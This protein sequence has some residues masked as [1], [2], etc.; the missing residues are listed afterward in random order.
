MTESIPL[1]LLT[2]FLGSGKTTLLNYL[3]QQP[4]FARSLVI[5]NE[6]GD[7]SLD[8]LLVT[9][10]A[11]DN[12]VQLSSGCICCS[13][14]GD[15][16]KTLRDISW[17]F[18]RNGVRQFEQV[19]IE[20][21]GL[22]APAAIIHTVMAEPKIARQ[23][24]LQGVIVTVDAVNGL[25]TL[26]RHREAQQQVAVAD[27]LLLTKTDLANPDQQ[28]ALRAQLS[29]LNL[30]AE[31]LGMTQGRIDPQQLLAL[32]HI[33]PQGSH[34]PLSQWINSSR[35]A[36]D[37][38]STTATALLSPHTSALTSA[39]AHASPIQSHAFIIDTP[40]PFSQFEQWLNMMVAQMAPNMLRIKGILHIAGFPGPMVIHGVQHLF[41]PAEF[42][43]S[44]PDADKRSRL[45]FITDGIS[46]EQLA[47]SLIKCGIEA[48]S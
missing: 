22:A 12:I 7:I 24:R 30:Q 39:T 15:L 10:S 19:I 38:A 33:E 42:M 5:I 2:G 43:A 47:Q 4:A 45:V 6:L 14:R 13:I 28:Q 18:S 16:A 48:V 27:L 20:T 21:T 23:F 17:R 41:H 46:R 31:Q 40:L 11:E 9:R 25:N 34:T 3:V 29:Q 36:A 1:F 26:A 35:F 32:D 8:H 44:W 37:T